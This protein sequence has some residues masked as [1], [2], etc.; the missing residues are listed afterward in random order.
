MLCCAVPCHAMPC[1]AMPCHAMPCHAMPCHAMPCHAMPCHAMPCHAMPCHAMPCHAM[2]CHAMPCHAMPHAMPMAM[3]SHCNAVPCCAM[4]CY[5]ILLC[6]AA[7]HYIVCYVTLLSILFSC[8]QT[9][10][11]NNLRNE[12]GPLLSNTLL[13]QIVFHLRRW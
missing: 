9:L 12:K 11:C 3:P 7:L 10:F 1:H 4:L 8:I 2:P 5:P 13:T 6:Y